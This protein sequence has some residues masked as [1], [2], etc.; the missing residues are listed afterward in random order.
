MEIIT[1]PNTS[2]EF[3]KYA[4]VLLRSKNIG[5]A[6]V[7][8][9]ESLQVPFRVKNIMKSAVAAGS[10]ADADWASGLSDYRQIS[11][12]F[13]E[14]LADASVFDRLLKD[15]AMRKIPLRTRVKLSSSIA[16][17][18]VGEGNAMPVSKSTI[19]SLNLESQKA[20][21]LIVISNELA[22][23]SSNEAASLLATELKNAVAEATDSKFLNEL[24]DGV[25]PTPSSGDTAVNVAA[26]IKTLLTS[27]TLK[28]TSR[29]YLITDSTIAA[30]LSVKT[31]TN[32]V[33]VYPKVTPMGGELFGIPLLVTDQLPR[34]SDG[35]SLMLIDASR[36]AG[37]N[38]SVLLDTS[39]QAVVEML[40]DPSEPSDPDTVF[41]SLWQ[42]SLRALSARRYFGF[43]LLEASAIA[44]IDAVN[45]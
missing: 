29:P 25:S 42:N 37:N 9:R 20:T 19:D 8:A 17:S 27:V 13:V 18:I 5:D 3:V 36:I 28:A 44:V 22:I 32:G 43:K 11:K 39:E 45:Y 30:N 16:G 15:N 40:S 7:F 33:P 24:L 2:G 23:S 21:A 6:E 41:L 12:N 26:D 34:D 31:D 1:R 35:G 4:Q 14:S 38:E 10:T